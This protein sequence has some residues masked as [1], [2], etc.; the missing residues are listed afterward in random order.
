MN[1]RSDTCI[2]Y[3]ISRDLHRGKL[4]YMHRIVSAKKKAEARSPLN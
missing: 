3:M 4:V 2:D 1:L